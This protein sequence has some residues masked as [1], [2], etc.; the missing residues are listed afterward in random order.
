MQEETCIKC[1]YYEKDGIKWYGYCID[2]DRKTPIELVFQCGEA[3]KIEEGEN[4]C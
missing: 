1:K 4:K 2:E 3:D